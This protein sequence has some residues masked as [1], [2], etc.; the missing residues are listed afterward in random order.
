MTLAFMTVI[1]FAAWTLAVLMFG[2]GTRRWYLILSRKA[3]LTSFPAD[4]PH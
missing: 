2:V 4:T 3:S 1:G